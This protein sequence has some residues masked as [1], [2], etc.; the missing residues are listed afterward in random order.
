MDHPSSSRPIRASVDA[1]EYTEA[2][3]YELL[4]VDH[5]AGRIPESQG[6]LSEDVEGKPSLEDGPPAN[7]VRE[8]S[9][10]FSMDEMVARTVPSTDDPSLPSLTFR[11]VLLGSV[12]CVLGAAASQVFY[13]K[14]NA[15]SFSIYFVLLTTYPL[16]NLMA[17][18]IPP[19][20]I[21]GIEMNPGPFS[22]KEHVLIGIIASSGG[23]SAYASDIVIILRLYYHKTMGAVSSIVL[24]IVTQC[25]GFGLAGMLQ[26]ILIK[27]TAMHWP[28]TLVTVQ[29]FTTLHDDRSKMT[30]KRLHIFM[31]VGTVCFFYQF[32]PSV[33]FPTLTSIATLCYINNNSWLLRTLGSGY[34]GLGMFNFSL[35][36]STI[37]SNGPLY[38]PWWA[39]LNYFAGLMG[40]IWIAVPLLLATNFWHAREFPAP[41]SAGL[42]NSTYEHFDVMGVLNADLSLND[43]AWEKAKPLL[44]TP[45]FAIS[46]G[47]NFAALSA[48]ITHVI[49]WHRSDILQAIRKRHLHED[50]HNKLMQAYESVPTSW[51]LGTLAVNLLAGT[52][53]VMTTDLQTPV[54]FLFF[55][56]AVAAAFL[57]PIGCITA[58]S[59]TTPGLN[60]LTEWI[61]GI[62]YPGRPIANVTFKCMGYMAMAQALN[63]LADQKLGHYMHVNPKHMFLAQTVGSIIGCFVNYAVLD[64]VIRAKRP[65]LDG[66]QIDPTGQWDGRKPFI[67]MNASVIWGVVAP[68]RFFAGQYQI[69]YLGFP[70]GVAIPLVCWYL[71]KRYPDTRFDFKKINFAIICDGATTVPQAP[72]N[73]IAT[74]FAVAF[75]ANVFLVKRYPEFF[76]NFIYVVSSALDAA[77]SLN[78]LAAYA[79][80][81]VLFTGI[82]PPGSSSIDS[83]HCLPGS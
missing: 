16:G 67:F 58:I 50:I 75:A 52:I 43:D 6:L 39:Q 9:D 83:E 80:F 13:F 79:F 51:Y 42:Y 48:V 69:L 68:K 49:I 34:N 47:L 2:E 70:L 77:T 55:A 15:P 71:H 40:M 24:L 66:S 35:D 20:R 78:A 61:A 74:S 38:T 81:N 14:S 23:T 59:N 33:F 1:N 29:L 76:K 31:V 21:C 65:F 7:G 73:V 28:A 56:V 44:L 45:Y 37:G 27:P 53:L 26:G 60:V 46:Y 32:L 82:S 19:M 54:W 17:T 11:A 41:T 57:I 30:Q 64:Q 12:F 63:L 62:I 4:E 5:D 36:W 22:I 25:T 8:E 72:A 10:A 18:Y 3:A